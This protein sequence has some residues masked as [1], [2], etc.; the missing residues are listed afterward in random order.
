MYQYNRV[1][2][3]MSRQRRNKDTEPF[4]NSLVYLK[5]NL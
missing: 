3:N 2:R 5:I 4:S 1:P